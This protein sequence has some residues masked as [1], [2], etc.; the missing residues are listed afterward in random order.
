VAGFSGGCKQSALKPINNLAA[1]VTSSRIDLLE[2]FK[3]GFAL[4]IDDAAGIRRTLKTMLRQIGVVN[5]MEADDGDTALR[6]LQSRSNC[7][8]ILVDW[9]MPRVPG[10]EVVRELR[11]IENTQEVPI[12]MITAETGRNQ[13]AEAAEAGVNGYILKPFVAKI[14][15]EKIFA[16]ISARSNPPEYVQLIK[17]GQ[18]LMIH[19]DYEKAYDFFQKANTLR[20]SARAHVAIGDVHDAWGDFDMAHGSYNAGIS[21]NPMFLRAYLRSAA[22]HLK[23]GNM[24]LALAALNKAADISPSNSDR[25]MAIAKI[26]LDKGNEKQALESFAKAL[27]Q[28]AHKAEEIA[29]ELLKAGKT[30]T[31]VL[32]FRASLQRDADNIHVYN[33]LGIAL[34]RQGKWK[35]AV[36]EYN[37]ALKIDPK[38]E[39]LYFN[40]GKAYVEGDQIKLAQD[41]FKKALGLNSGFNEAKDALNNLSRKVTF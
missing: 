21:L 32:Y 31:S 25:H 3:N 26:H 5:T 36:H 33:R 29:E 10:I 7:L 12:L 14:L 6:T 35:E 41:A 18:D 23:Q 16:I 39:G 40:M 24:D 22:L 15:E 4:V 20:E 9:N 28:G 34:R 8:F 38:D 19:G 2:Y 1:K 13:V 37:T 17:K 27:R 30:E 11:A